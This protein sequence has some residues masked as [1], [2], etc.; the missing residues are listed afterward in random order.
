MS[1]QSPSPAVTFAWSDGLTSPTESPVL[2]WVRIV[3]D[4]VTTI[5]QSITTGTAVHRSAAAKDLPAGVVDAY[6]AAEM[7]FVASGS[8]AGGIAFQTAAPSVGFQLGDDAAPRTVLAREQA[9][10]A[11]VAADAAARDVW[12]AVAALEAAAA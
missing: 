5:D 4:K 11:L 10:P 2:H 1:L 8:T 9:S 6:R 7:A 12:A 3:D